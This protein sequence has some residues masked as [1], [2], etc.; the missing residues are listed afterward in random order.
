MTAAALAR[1]G[2]GAARRRGGHRHLVLLMSA[3]GRWPRRRR[4]C[5]VGAGRQRGGVRRVSVLLLAGARRCAAAGAPHPHTPTRRALVGGCAVWHGS[6]GTAAGPHRRRWS[7]R[8]R[9]CGTTVERVTVVR[10]RGDGPMLADGSLGRRG[11]RWCWTTVLL[12]MA[13]CSCCWSIVSV[14]KAVQI[15]PQAQAAVIERLG[16]YQRTRRPGLVFLVPFI[17]RIRARIDLREQVVSFPPQPVIT[18]D[19]LTVNIDTVVYYQVTDPQGRGLRDR[20]LHR[21]RRADHDHDAAQ[22]GRRD[23]PGG[24]R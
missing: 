14:V 18:Q 8:A 3:A 9:R 17:D 23:E 15:I 20:R 6:T 4:P 11:A 10:S 16:R 24:A 13:C 22:R 1:R 7:A 2:P 5:S 21:R 19:N 12:V